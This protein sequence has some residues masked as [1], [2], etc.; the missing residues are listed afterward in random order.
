LSALPGTPRGWPQA[1]SSAE[2]AVAAGR[3]STTAPPGNGYLMTQ[4]R[5][6]LGENAAAPPR[7]SPLEGAATARRLLRRR[8]EAADDLEGRRRPDVRLRGRF[9]PLPCGE[10]ASFGAGGA[11]LSA[12]GPVRAVMCSLPG[13]TDT[14]SGL[15]DAWRISWRTSRRC[16]CSPTVTT[17]P[18][19]PARAVR[20]DRCR[21]ALCS[22]GGS[23][24]TTSSMSST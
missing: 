22:A 7:E 18:L 8:V 14:T 24:C 17:W 10:A 4:R 21:Y 23:T 2:T 19:A 11:T 9:W 15:I 20:P 16:S 3:C 1:T 12:A 6:D 13:V 5:R